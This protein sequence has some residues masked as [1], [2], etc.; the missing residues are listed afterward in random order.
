MTTPAIL[1]IVFRRPEVTARVFE[2][3]RQA[4]PERLYLAAD[5]P[6]AVVPGEAERCAQTRAIVSS[7]D[8]PCDV[9]TLFRDEN[10]GVRRGVSEAI[11]WFFQHESEGII[12]EDDCLPSPEFSCEW[13]TVE[14]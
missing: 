4:R 12:F 14:I 3:L 10:V 5:G 7:V 1:F 2:A 6:R 8:W 9:K 13:N 11:S